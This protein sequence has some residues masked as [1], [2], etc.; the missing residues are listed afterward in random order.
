MTHNMT[1]PRPPAAG[2]PGWPADVAD[3]LGKAE[4]YLQDGQ[5]GRAIDLLARAKSPSPWVTNALGVCQ[6][7]QG[8][9]RLAIEV[10]RGLVLGSGGLILREDVP[11]VF[12]TNFATA[13][14][15]GGNLAG[16][17]RILDE[18]HDEQDPAVRRIRAAV[19]RWQDGLSFWEKVR[20]A[21]GGDPPRPVVLAFPPGDLG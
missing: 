15:A 2:A 14:L 16:C 13:L 4:V 11:V 21:L 18:I 3:L 8:N 5:P 6:L 19:E 20:W 10:F 9:A 1:A 17:L 12:K 7:R